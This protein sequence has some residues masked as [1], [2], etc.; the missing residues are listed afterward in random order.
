[1]GNNFVSAET[2]DLICNALNVKPRT[3]F[4][5][6]YLEAKNES[7]FDDVIEKIKDKPEILKVIHKIVVALQN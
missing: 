4:D 7:L 5:F 2:L 1:M 3:L 6:D